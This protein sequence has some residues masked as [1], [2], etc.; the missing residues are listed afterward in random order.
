MSEKKFLPCHKMVE[1]IIFLFP[2]LTPPLGGGVKRGTKAKLGC[3]RDSV[4]VAKQGASLQSKPSTQPRKQP[5]VV[6][7]RSSCSATT[8]LLRPPKGGSK[9]SFYLFRGRGVKLCF[10][11]KKDRVRIKN[12]GREKSQF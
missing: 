8:W 3:W 6:L 7:Q 9:N 12:F 5:L 10:Y 11:R 4:W 2:F 1:D